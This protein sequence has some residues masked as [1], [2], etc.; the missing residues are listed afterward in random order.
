MIHEAVL[1]DRLENGKVQ[2]HV[3]SHE[4]TIAKGKSGICG[5][6]ENR[7]GTLFT[8]IYNTVSSE[9]VDPI[10]KKPLYHFLP[11][12]LSYSQGTIGCNF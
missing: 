9:A 1:F 8:L 5:V 4:C 7:D 2:C 12:T 10:E 3:C 11:G 6:R